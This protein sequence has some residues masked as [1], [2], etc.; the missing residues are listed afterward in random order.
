MNR[1]GIGG[2]SDEVSK[3]LGGKKSFVGDVFAQ[4][5]LVEVQVGGGGELPPHGLLGLHQLRGGAA[6]QHGM[7]LLL[8]R[9]LPASPIPLSPL[10]LPL[11]L[12]LPPLLHGELVALDL[13]D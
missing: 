9:L 2:G 8:R 1:V 11:P 13:L 3:L 6:L 4:R 10:L 7:V 12:P 5:L